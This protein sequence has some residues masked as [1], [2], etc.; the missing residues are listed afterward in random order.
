MG[1]TTKQRDIDDAFTLTDENVNEET[2]KR[3]NPLRVMLTVILTGGRK[4]KRALSSKRAKAIYAGGLSLVVSALILAGLIYFGAYVTNVLM[5]ANPTA[6]WA[7]IGGVMGVFYIRTARVIYRGLKG[8][9]NGLREGI[10]E[11]RSSNP[12]EAAMAGG[13]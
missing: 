6:A 9:F 10:A 12:V 1:N 11:R 8:L 2:E 13:I 3:D 5:V 7:I 4:A